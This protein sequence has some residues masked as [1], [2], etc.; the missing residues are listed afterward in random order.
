MSITSAIIFMGSLIFLAHLC[1]NLFEYTKI[2]TVLILIIIG[3]LI[4]PILSLATPENFGSLG[5]VFTTITLIVILFE[6]GTGLRLSSLKASIGSATIVTIVNFIVS[7][8]VVTLLLMLTTQF[9]WRSALYLGF[10]IG[11]TSSAVVI[12]MVRQLHLGEKSQ[13]ILFLES[14]LSDVLCLILSLAIL[15]SFESDAVSFSSIGLSILLSLTLALLFGAALGLIWS[16][17]QQA[18]F[19]NLS[20]FMFTSFALAFILYGVCDLIGLNGGIAVL[21][22]GIILGNLEYYSENKIIKKIFRQ[23]QV[24]LKTNE[25]N[26]FSEIGFI[27]QTYFFVYVGMSLKFGNIRLLA[28]GAI[29][30]AAIFALRHFINRWLISKNT[31]KFDKRIVGIMTPKG[32]VAAVLASI[33]LQMGLPFG[34]EIQDIAYAVVFFSIVLCSIMVI[35]EKNKQKREEKEEEEEETEIINTDENTD[36]VEYETVIM[37]PTQEEEE[38]E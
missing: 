30:T 33:P 1:N 38:K 16:Y 15:S 22:F 29:I 9:D 10:A 2:P 4:G 11:G 7:A 8:T 27:L 23:Y 18:L 3:I 20:N 36:D 34:E 28:I 25:R 24:G 35:I 6:S 21:S 26:F 19:R 5:S 14:A 17:I 12:P 31:P 32:L 37:H 13:T